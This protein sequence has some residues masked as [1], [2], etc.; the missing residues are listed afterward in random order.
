MTCPAR[1]SAPALDLAKLDDGLGRRLQFYETAYAAFRL[2]YC[3]LAS[4]TLAGSEDGERFLRGAAAYRRAL[5]ERGSG[6]LL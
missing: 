3:I 4:G 2:G 1:D 5:A 6:L